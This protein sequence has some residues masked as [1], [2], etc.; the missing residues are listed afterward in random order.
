[1]QAQAIITTIAADSRCSPAAVTKR[2][3]SSRLM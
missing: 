1:V 3:T 2:F